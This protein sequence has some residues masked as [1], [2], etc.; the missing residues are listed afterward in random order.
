[1]HIISSK[2]DIETYVGNHLSGG[3]SLITDA[4]HD[5]L[6]KAIQRAE[7]PPYGE[8]WSEWLDEHAMAL[9]DGVLFPET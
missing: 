9:R 7:H 6:V 2:T 1:M 3:E 4:Q 5:A 8:D